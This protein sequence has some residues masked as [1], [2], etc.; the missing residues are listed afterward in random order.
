MRSLAFLPLL[1]VAGC[2]EPPATKIRLLDG[3]VLRLEVAVRELERADGLGRSTLSAEDI[4]EIRRLTH[5]LDGRLGGETDPAA[6]L[7][8][9]ALVK[10]E[11]GHY[12]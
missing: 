2:S 1:L 11:L 8:L 3:A 9:E 5:D 6:D 12:N 10:R 4:A 7:E